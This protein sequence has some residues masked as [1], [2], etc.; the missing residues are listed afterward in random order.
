MGTVQ[1]S[2]N[3]AYLDYKKFMF[4]WYLSFAIGFGAI[5]VNVGVCLWLADPTEMINDSKV[6]MM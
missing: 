5:L 3:K 2:L 6:I 4:L 1:Y